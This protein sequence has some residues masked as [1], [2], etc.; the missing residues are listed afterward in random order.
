MKTREFANFSGFFLYIFKWC[1]FIHNDNFY[2]Y[3]K[4]E[5][6]INEHQLDAS[7]TLIIV[8]ALTLG[9]HWLLL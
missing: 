6:L 8:F 4:G 5:F 9:L 3:E 1:E 7:I 2:R